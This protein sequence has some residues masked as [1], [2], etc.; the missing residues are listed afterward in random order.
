MKCQYCNNALP[1][2]V[3]HCPSCGAPAP[4]DV[5][6][7]AVPRGPGAAAPRRRLIQAEPSAAW[8]VGLLVVFAV[9][10]VVEVFAGKTWW[11]AAAATVALGIPFAIISRVYV[12][13]ARRQWRSGN[14]EKATDDDVRSGCWL[15]LAIFIV[16]MSAVLCFA[17]SIL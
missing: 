6:S 17:V 15:S 5:Q 11:L 4:E 14:V 7:Q 9:I 12:G 10:G 1:P 2:G 8:Q 3:A 13:K 16:G